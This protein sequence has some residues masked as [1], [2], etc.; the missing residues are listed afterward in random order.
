MCG[1]ANARGPKTRFPHPPK[2]EKVLRGIRQRLASDEGFTLVELLAVIM[3]IGVLAAIALP[4]FL[5]AQSKGQDADAKTNAGNVSKAVELCFV[6]KKDYTS[7]DTAPEISAVAGAPSAELTDAATKKQG[8]VSVAATS[9][10]Y[11]IVGYS[12][13]DNTFTVTRPSGADITRTCTAAGTGG[14]HTGS[15]W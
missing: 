7:C 3:I 15:V 14:C 10:S 8:A 1:R 13:S 5:G 11:E 12:K 2:D 4:N 9:D 6:E